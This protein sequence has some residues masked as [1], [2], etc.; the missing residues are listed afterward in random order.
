MGKKK[1]KNIKHH[2]N[3]EKKD[4]GLPEGQSLVSLSS[5]IS[6][7]LMFY[8]EDK[9][10]SLIVDDN[11]INKDLTL[12]SFE[13][14]FQLELDKFIVDLKKVPSKIIIELKDENKNTE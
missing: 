2:K 12:T 3:T 10:I 9:K 11:T 6:N 8:L 4:K 1:N 14:N 7:F 5:L 13:Y